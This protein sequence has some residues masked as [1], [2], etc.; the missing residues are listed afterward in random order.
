MPL[1]FSAL[2]TGPVEY[3]RDGGP[4]AY[5]RPPERGVSD[6]AGNPCRHCLADIP[7][8]A[9]MLILA[10]RPFPEPQP[11]AETGPIFLCAD[12]CPRHPDTPALPALFAGRDALMIRGY[13]LDHRIVYGTGQV[14]PT[15]R[16]AA[17]AAELLAER[18]VAY[19]HLRSA[20]NNCYQARIDRAA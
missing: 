1:L 7:A 13:G 11:Y 14:A 16:I 19:L 8:G 10:W 15:A 3:L 5:G 20:R 2:P 4:D 6:G 9:P 18:R 17:L 12:S